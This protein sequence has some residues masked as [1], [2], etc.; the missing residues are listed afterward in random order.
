MMTD[1]NEFEIAYNAA[2]R[3][4]KQAKALYEKKQFETAHLILSEALLDVERARDAAVAQI[5]V[6][7]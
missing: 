3:R 2:K 4:L 5:G 7:K 1:P 6:D